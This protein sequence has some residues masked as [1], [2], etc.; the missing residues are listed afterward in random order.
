MILGFSKWLSIGSLEFNANGKIIALVTP[1]K[2]GK[3]GMP[4]PVKK[5]DKLD[6]L[7]ITSNQQM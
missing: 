2:A 7:A 3:A 6:R 5:T 1:L 4:G